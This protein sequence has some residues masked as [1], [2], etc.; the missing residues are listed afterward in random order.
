MQPDLTLR[1]TAKLVDGAENELTDDMPLTELLNR[2]GHG[3]C[4][5]TLN[6]A[7]KQP[8]QAVSGHRAVVERA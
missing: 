6:P 8:S 1:A 2:T 3:R 5:I 4:V 7:D